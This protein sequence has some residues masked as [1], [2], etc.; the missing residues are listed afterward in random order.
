MASLPSKWP[1]ESYLVVFLNA[2]L[3]GNLFFFRA[4]LGPISDVLED[5]FGMSSSG[6]SLLSSSFYWIYVPANIPWGLFMQI[7]VPEASS[8][9]AAFTLTITCVLFPMSKHTAYPLVFGCIVRAVAGAFTVQLFLAGCTLGAHRFG[10]K[11]VGLVTGFT[12]M[13]GTAHAVVG[14]VL[15]ALIYEKYQDW[16]SVYFG[17]AAMSF[18]Y[19]MLLLILKLRGPDGC[20]FRRAS[21]HENEADTKSNGDRTVTITSGES[22]SRRESEKM[23]MSLWAQTKVN[24]EQAIKLWLNWIAGLIGLC[25]GIIFFGIYNL[26]FV[27]YLMV[28]NGYSRTLAS[29]VVSLGLAGSGVGLLGFGE[30][31]RR[32][33]RR[34]PLVFIGIAMYSLIIV[35]IYVPDLPL[36]V[37]ITLSI[38]IGMA[39]GSTPLLYVLGREYNWY[40]GAAETATGLINMLVLSSGFIGQFTIGA[41]LDFHHEKRVGDGGDPYNGN[42]YKFAFTVAPVA[43][44]IMLILTFVLKETN[45]ENV[46]HDTESTH[47]E[48]MSGTQRI[49]HAVSEENDSQVIGKATCP[50]DENLA[51]K[52]M[53]D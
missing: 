11:H 9:F 14:G 8:I 34:K 33:S 22:I 41:L 16:E 25:G 38:I 30:L 31:S 26:W 6:L 36:G 2:L 12:V 28:T 40:H 35:M 17:I 43:V 4:S 20:H 1:L 52:E 19:G 53:T 27:P 15:Q 18:S 32:C 13:V 21:N 5:E 47:K 45:G 51:Q 7:Y 29:I 46:I 37:V 50:S 10:N 48:A 24:L 3:F 49:T 44:L 39:F 23:K 42:D